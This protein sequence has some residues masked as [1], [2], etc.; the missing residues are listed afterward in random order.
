M[1]TALIVGYGNSLRGDD[2]IGEVVAQ[3]FAA[4]AIDG[5]EVVIFNS[6]LNSLSAC[7]GRSISSLMPRPTFNPAQYRHHPLRARR[8]SRWAL[9]TI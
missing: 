2:A 6:H 4:E 9:S 7:R 1:G 8:H 5:A 3:A